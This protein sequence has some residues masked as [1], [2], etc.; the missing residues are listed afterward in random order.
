MAGEER[1]PYPPPYD[2]ELTGKRR[3]ALG[4]ALGLTKFGVNLTRLAPGA[5]SS[6]RHWHTEEDEFVY[7]LEG[8]L[9]LV[10]DDGEQLLGPGAA[11]GFPAGRADAHRLVNN[12]DAPAVYLEVGNRASAEEVHYAEA[13]LVL[14]RTAGGERVFRH[15]NGEPY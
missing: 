5:V 4:D 12:S 11:A 2:T 13:D 8:T 1:Q 6:L 3:H 15:R 9:T 14:T 10:T 7:V